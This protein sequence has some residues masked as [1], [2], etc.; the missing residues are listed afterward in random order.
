MATRLRRTSRTLTL[1]VSLS[2]AALAALS[3]TLLAG[4]ADLGTY[5]WVDDLSAQNF[6]PAVKKGDYHLAVGDVINVRVL[7]QE[8]LTTHTR[9]RTDGRIAFP[10]LGDVDVAGKRPN[11]VRNELADRLRKF[12]VNPDVTVSVEERQP[13]YASVV[14]E[15][16]RAGTVTIQPGAGV[17]DAIAQAGGLTDFASK[18]RIFVIRQAPKGPAQRIRFTYDGLTHAEGRAASFQLESG[19][20]IVCE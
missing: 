10:M 6:S 14:G 1:T 13:T 5:E 3:C 12:L 18:D 20:V 4:C 15:V 8:P 17:L 2:T 19:D 7:N 16:A 9:V 11:D